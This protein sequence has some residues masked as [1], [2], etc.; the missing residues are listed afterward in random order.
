MPALYYAV[1]LFGSMFDLSTSWLTSRKQMILATMTICCVIYAY[2]IFIPITYGESWSQTS[3]ENSKWANSWD[4]D[5][6]Q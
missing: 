2:R 5:C 1:L 3:C 6:V 4:F